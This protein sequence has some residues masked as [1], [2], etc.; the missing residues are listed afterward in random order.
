[1]HEGEYIVPAPGSQAVLAPVGEGG[2]V[3]N[4][5]FPVEVE[6][7]GELRPAAV[8]QVAA[9]VFAELERE[10]KSRR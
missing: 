4:Y 7:V 1:M 6:L 10:L 8:E 2:T 3:V 9:H 5:W